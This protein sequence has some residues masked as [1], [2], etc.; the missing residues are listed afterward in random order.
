MS[1][2][3]LIVILVFA[4][5]FAVA[6]PTVIGDLKTSRHKTMKKEF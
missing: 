5:L 6:V 3:L 4:A 2:L 1:D